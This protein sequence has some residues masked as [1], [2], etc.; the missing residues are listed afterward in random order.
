M[1]PLRPWHARLAGSARLAAALAAESRLPF[2]PLEAIRHAQARRVRAMVVHAFRTVPHYRDAMRRLGLTPADFTS[3]DDLER[4]PMIERSELQRDPER[5]RS[6][7]FASRDLLE[8]HSG[9]RTG[10][11]VAVWH[12]LP[13]VIANAAHGERDRA[14]WAGSLVPLTGYREAVLGMLDGA[15]ASVQ[16]FLRRGIMLPARADIERRYLSGLDPVPRTLAALNAFRPHVVH[17]YGS[18]LEFLF[19][20]I[21]SSGAPFER[22]AVVTYSSDDLSSATRQFVERNLGVPVFATYE[23]IEAFKIG[24]ECGRRNGYHLNVDLYPLRVDGSG[25]VIVSNLVNRATVLLNYRLGDRAELSPGACSCGRRLPLMSRLD[26]RRDGVLRR[27][28]GTGLLP[29]AVAIIFS[30]TP[31]VQHYQVQEVERLRLVVRLVVDAA[32][33]RRSVETHVAAALARA[34]GDPVRLRVDFVDRIEPTAGGKFQRIL[35]Y[36]YDD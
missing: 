26:G 16:R 12:D 25:D 36:P 10:E 7:A 15:D 27:A 17:G 8:L 4:L 34:I 11:P 18:M 6:S 14:V 29:I 19:A 1:P 22:P 23:A 28:D 9:G 21:A 30:H 3:A 5:F 31:G 24:F 2:R 13:A 20:H 32:C 33:D 35:P